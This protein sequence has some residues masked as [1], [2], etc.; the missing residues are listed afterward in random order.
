MIEPN[1]GFDI[2]SICVDVLRSAQRRT[3]VPALAAATI[4]LVQNNGT[5]NVYALPG[6]S[7]VVVEPSCRAAL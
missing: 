5:E 2:T 4:A 7:S 1:H 3:E 6:T